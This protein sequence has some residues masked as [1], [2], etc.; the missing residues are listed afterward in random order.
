MY[1]PLASTRPHTDCVLSPNDATEVGVESP[2]ETNSP[3][4]PVNEE[5]ASIIIVGVVGL[6]ISAVLF[7]CPSSMPPK[8]A[9][10]EQ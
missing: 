7:K 9:E 1:C 5:L 6:P 8:Q 4:F 10:S 2:V 3:T